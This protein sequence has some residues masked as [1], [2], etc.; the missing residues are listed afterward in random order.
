VI[1]TRTSAKAKPLHDAGAHHLI[2]TTE[3]D[4]AARVQ[5]ITNGKG[6]RVVFDPIGGPALSQLA[7]CMSFGGILLE[8][9]APSTEDGTFPQFALHF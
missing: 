7:G 8:Y 4:V 6:A 2:A 3:E 5:E 9:G 1:T